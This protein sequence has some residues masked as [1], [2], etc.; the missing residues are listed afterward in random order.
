[1]KHCSCCHCIVF[2]PPTL[3]PNGIVIVPEGTNISLSCASTNLIEPTITWTRGLAAQLVS[4]PSTNSLTYTIPNTTINTSDTYT[5]SVVY[6]VGIV[7]W[8]IQKERSV[9][10]DVKSKQF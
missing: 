9:T 2:G 5:C 1:M 4:V 6:E 10:I 3:T 8:V 7:P